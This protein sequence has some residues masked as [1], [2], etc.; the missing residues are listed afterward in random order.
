[1]N[2]TSGAGKTTTARELVTGRLD[3]VDV[4]FDDAGVPGKGEAGDDGGTVAVDAGGSE[5]AQSAAF[6]LDGPAAGPVGD[7]DPSATT[8]PDA[9]PDP[10]H[11]DQLARGLV[12]A[13]HSN[14]LRGATPWDALSETDRD[15]HRTDAP[16]QRWHRINTKAVEVRLPHRDV[17]REPFGLLTAFRAELH[18]SMTGRAD[19]LFELTDAMLCAEPGRSGRRGGRVRPRE[20]PPPVRGAGFSGREVPWLVATSPWNPGS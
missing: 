2:G 19:A 15:Q 1:M 18:A 3:A 14:G 12:G 16:P 6:D 17:T 13:A 8:P 10:R 9:E 5:G 4:S 7:S 20:S 11:V